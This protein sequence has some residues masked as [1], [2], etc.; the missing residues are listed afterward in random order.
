MNP[1]ESCTQP[2]SAEPET[3]AELL[4]VKD[5]VERTEISTSK[6]MQQEV[7]KE[8]QWGR[9]LSPSPLMD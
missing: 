6:N 1:K 9:A 2:N 4:T 5:L 3:S 8:K 7:W